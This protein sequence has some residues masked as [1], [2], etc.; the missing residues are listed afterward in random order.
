M[1]DASFKW[2]AQLITLHNERCGAAPSTS[3]TLCTASFKFSLT[4]HSSSLQFKYDGRSSIQFTVQFSS[5]YS[6]QF[7]YGGCSNM[8]FTFHFSSF[9]ISHYRQTR[10]QGEHD[11]QGVES[12]SVLL[13]PCH[14]VPHNTV[15]IPHHVV[16]SH[17]TLCSY[18]SMPYHATL[19]SYVYHIT[20]C[21]DTQSCVH[22][23]STHTCLKLSNSK[24]G[25]TTT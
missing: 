24:L 9:H 20:P 19:H 16:P 7:K 25:A 22:V 5:V 10:C 14:A 15:S 8:Q 18:H 21:H 1:I 2:S 23:Q 6:L 3:A 13:A 12:H 17:T 11:S 4:V